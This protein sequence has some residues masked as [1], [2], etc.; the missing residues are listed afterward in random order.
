MRF[1]YRSG[2]WHLALSMFRGD[3][4]RM[5]NESLGFSHNAITVKSR[6]GALES[7][8]FKRVKLDSILDLIP[9]Q[10]NHDDGF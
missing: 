2:D 9:S 1:Q 3:G 7:T 10:N 8:R 4:N 5:H 6:V